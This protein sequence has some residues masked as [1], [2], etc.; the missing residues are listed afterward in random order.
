MLFQA[1]CPVAPSMVVCRS[2]SSASDSGLLRS[3]VAIAVAR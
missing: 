3:A 2:V 1:N